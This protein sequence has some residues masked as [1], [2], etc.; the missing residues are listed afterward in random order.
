MFDGIMNADLFIFDGVSWVI[1][2]LVTFIGAVVTRFS[3]RY[4]DGEPNRKSFIFRIFALCVTALGAVCANHFAV[5]FVAWAA[6][7]WQLS[8]LIGWE[9][10]WP[11]AR[12]AQK[13]A[14]YHFLGSSLCLALALAILARV[15]GCYALDSL[16]A[17]LFGKPTI[18]TASAGFLILIA[19]WVQSA[20]IPFHRWLSNSMTA[21][22]PVSALMHAGI[23]N[24]GGILL[25]RFQAIL[26][27]SQILSTIT[28]A[29]GLLSAILGA[30]WM[31]VISDVKR[32]LAFSTVSQ[33]GYMMLQAGLG[34]YKAVIAHLILH[35]LFKAY[36]FLSAGSVLGAP[37][38]PEE[39]QL[40]PSPMV[41]IP[42][43]I[44]AVLGSLLFLS[45]TH[46][47]SRPLNTSVVL[48][49]FVGLAG[50]R[51]TF[52]FLRPPQRLTI[53]RWSLSR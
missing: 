32:S 23:V 14:R 44:N 8:S 39:P 29:V 49:F 5:L 42:A 36:K 38:A 53:S 28:G 10:S 25:F 40:K 35:G 18:L 17:A 43:L 41:V 52:L 20:T 6:T 34:A 30:L 24:S 13:V 37:T 1:F 47:I 46:E 15:G 16:R 50:A 22:T 45:L 4:M 3:V 19:A 31:M 11:A 12:T 27:H 9:K 48:A 33:M 26:G 7:G 51:L 2:G 21:P